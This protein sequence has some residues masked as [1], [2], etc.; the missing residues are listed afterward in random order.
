MHLADVLKSALGQT[1]VSKAHN[2]RASDGIQQLPPG[3]ALPRPLQILG[4]ALRPGPF[5][6]QAQADFGDL[7]TL[8]LDLRS[9]R[10]SVFVADPGVVKRIFSDP[11]LTAVGDARSLLPEVFGRHS[12][13]VADDEVHAAQRKLL[14]PGFQQSRFGRY[15]ESILAATDKAID[16][17]PT[18]QPF[19]LRPSLHAA[20]LTVIISLVFGRGHLVEQARLS[21]HVEDLLRV[22]ATP[23]AF[24][25]QALPTSVRL[26]ISRRRLG[27]RRTELDRA[28][29]D[30][31]ARARAGDVEGDTVLADLVF[32]DAD[33]ASLNDDYICDQLRTLL[34]AGHETS[35]TS[36][37]WTLTHLVH[38]PSTLELLSDAARNDPDTAVSYADA[39]ISESLRLTP[40]LPSV[41]RVLTTPLETDDYRLPENTIVVPCAYLIHRREEI[42]PD[43]NVFDPSRF[44]G[45]R[46]G[47][48]W[49]PFGGG[50]RRC[51][52]APLA[53][54][55]L[56][57]M[58]RRICE[59]TRLHASGPP[60]N[61]RRRGLVLAPSH[62][63]RVVLEERRAI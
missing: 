55:Q 17:W 8:R 30:E 56:N 6:K 16:S 51:L 10:P 53:R 7:F 52:G 3:P 57:V 44:L 58:L 41:Q 18:N 15:R 39:A 36:L 60:E 49:L 2:G 13:L 25:A 28:I 26:P 20:S 12:I 4:W 19:S 38:T 59:R 9:D 11:S 40:P 31:V 46:E 45:R 23:S 62:E 21:H 29:I 32:A 37:A 27:R 1:E 54:F 42:Y 43:P 14:R 33:S 35:A 63:G 48:S 47:A 22:V 24:L 5:L 50:S 34:L 61:M